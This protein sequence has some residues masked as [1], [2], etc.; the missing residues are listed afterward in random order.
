MIAPLIGM[1]F[2]S[3]LILLI[4]SAFAASIVHHAIRYRFLDPTEGFFSKWI[5]AW[6][7]AWLGPAVIG[8]WF[9][10]VMLWDVY[11][12]PALIGAFVGA[13]IVTAAFRAVAR[14]RIHA[15]VETF[16]Q[17]RVA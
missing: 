3:F 12:I 14:T 5:I 2:L 11:I 1:R 15:H 8:H 17:H 13:F 7:C 10:P 4:L 16:E 6:I 9:S